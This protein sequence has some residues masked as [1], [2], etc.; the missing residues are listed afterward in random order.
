MD[1]NIFENPNKYL[2]QLDKTKFFDKRIVE[3]EKKAYNGLSLACVWPTKLCPLGC[4]TCFFKSTIEYYYK[5]LSEADKEKC[6]R[7]LVD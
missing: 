3:E 4:E 5:Y 2:E 7:F 6:N 1:N